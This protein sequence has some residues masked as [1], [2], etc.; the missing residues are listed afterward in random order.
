MFNIGY[1]NSALERHKDAASR[2]EACYERMVAEYGEIRR[3][4]AAAIDVLQIV[5]G[6]VNSI[7]NTPACFKASIN[8]I[9]A[10]RDY[11]LA[12]ASYEDEALDAA[13]KGGV[14]TVSGI[15]VGTGLAVAG[16][17]LAKA[18]IAKSAGAAAIKAV[19][20]KSAFAGGKMV[21]SSMGGFTV[22]KS[23]VWFGPVGWAIAGGGVV[24]G[25]YSISKKN[26][27]IAEEV[28]DEA[29]KIEIASTKLEDISARAAIQTRLIK[30]QSS[31]LGAQLED[32]K[33][34]HCA[35][36]TEIDPDSK[37]MLGT[38]TNNARTLS[39]LVGQ[40]L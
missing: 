20:V 34:L 24:W 7:K 6:L 3:V 30:D 2:Y 8:D 25:A 5:E 36:Y 4:K 26:K 19:A 33:H 32:L 39:A 28:Y 40:G 12:A 29:R 15:V 37:T 27:K 23:S 22:A 38:L 35:N 21:L 17:I 14:I 10:S 13:I 18:A 11:F 1:R 16:P 9:V 31:N